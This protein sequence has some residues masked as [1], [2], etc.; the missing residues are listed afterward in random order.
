MEI[1]PTYVSFEQ[2][3]LL[4][5]DVFK[6]TKCYDENG[7]SFTVSL[8]IRKFKD[9]TY[10]SMPEQ[11]QAVEWLRIKY[12]IWVE[13]TAY[14]VEDDIEQIADEIWHFK[15]DVMSPKNRK[16]HSDFVKDKFLSPQEAYSAAF[17][18]IL[19]NLI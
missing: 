2:A 19:N 1:K 5:Q 7:N 4:P 8:T 3:K 14:D 12:G 13:V 6:T 15:C 18:Y 10:Y 16:S 11:W 17:D 9:K